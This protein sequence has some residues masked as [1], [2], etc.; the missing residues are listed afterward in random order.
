VARRVDVV[1]V[2]AGRSRGT[3]F[4]IDGDRVLTALHVIG[5]S[6]QGE[7]V[8]HDSTIQLTAAAAGA[9]AFRFLAAICTRQDVTEFDDQLDWACIRVDE[10]ALRGVRPLSLRTLDES[11]QSASWDTYGFPDGAEED[12]KATTGT[13]ASTAASF[14]VRSV[15]VAAIQVFSREAAAAGGG[16]VRGY[17]GAPVIVDGHGVGILCA[18]EQENGRS[19]EGTLYAIPL[20]SIAGRLGLP[21]LPLLRR[22]SGEAPE[23]HSRDGVPGPSS[24]DWER[25]VEAI[26]RLFCEAN[27]RFATD[28]LGAA[29]D[30]A[31]VVERIVD[32]L[33][34]RELERAGH[35]ES[36]DEKLRRLHAKGVIPRR[37]EVHFGTVYRHVKSFIHPDTVPRRP[38]PRELESGFGSLAIV[39]EWFFSYLKRPAPPA[40]RRPKRLNEALI[41]ATPISTMSTATI[42]TRFP[43][44]GE[45]SPVWRT[46]PTVSSLRF[47]APDGQ[48]SEQRS[49]KVEDAGRAYFIGR[50]VRKDGTP[51]DFAFPTTK[52]WAS[53]SHDAGV[54]TTRDREVVLKNTSGKNNMFVRG[55]VL[56]HGASRALR[57]G[58]SVQLGRCVGT[59]AD[60]RY[61]QATQASAIDPYTGLLSRLGLRSEIANVLATGKPRILLVLRGSERAAYD[62]E[63]PP[64]FDPERRAADA[65]LAI[66][67]HDP[68]VPIA[69]IGSDVAALLAT[70]ARVEAYTAVASS[71]LG[72]A[73][74]AGFLA[75][76]GMADQ[77]GPRLEACLGALSRIAMSGSKPSGPADLAKYALVPAPLS[78]FAE[79]AQPLFQAGGGAV[80]FAL[81]EIER[82]EDVSPHALPVLELELLEML[83]SRM[84]PRDL[85]SF[86]GPGLLAFATPGDVERFAHE[87][88]VTW[89][90]RGPATV[91]ALEIDRS[92]SA[93]ALD[94]DDLRELPRRAPAL[95]QGAIGILGLS[96]FPSPFAFAAR[97]IDEASDEVGREQRLIELVELAWQL[98]AFVLSAGA[99]AAK[100]PAGTAIPPPAGSTW[101]APWRVIARE[102]ALRLKDSVGRMNDLATAALA[103]DS[104]GPFQSAMATIASGAMPLG[105]A[106]TDGPASPGGVPRLERAVRDV[107]SALSPLRGW[108]LAAV[109]DA[110]AVDVDGTIQRVE[111]VDYTGA[112][113]Q[114]SRRHVSVIGFRSL[115]RFVY[116]A[117][118]AEGLAVA[119][120]PFVRRGRSEPA[121]D[122]ELFLAVAPIVAPGSHSYRSVATGRQMELPVTSKQLGSGR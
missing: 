55:E 36:F 107:V 7:L 60:G 38:E 37:E 66:H 118:W 53:I 29:I 110:E 67:R 18:A 52:T 48:P 100:S 117:R 90:A 10:E 89:H 39:V 120:E 51:N 61:Y 108:T 3:G 80:L 82:L 98:L 33:I 114:G 49:F 104:D 14:R 94:L 9:T 112:S 30:A 121:A 54:L 31:H 78:T 72:A 62:Q 111:Y 5:S 8:L 40:S 92:I 11:A 47:D 57:H 69:A 96:G 34:E 13:I 76:R 105:G 24:F 45:F 25:K 43:G 1:R 68:S 109:E 46:T 71:T 115:G 4:L 17:S 91:N 28:S 101:P 56:A 19:V 64:G 99:R 73:S 81:G 102:A 23:D 22:R 97:S 6:G 85:V 12:G 106:R 41:D 32:Y 83:G 35:D 103:A 122:E 27:D 84:G 116:L 86:A 65:A 42:G 59:F 63:S 87:T 44:I 77:A 21:P 113:A 70:D 88:S 74:V 58:D 20:A 26:A 93:H 75:L 15:S 119:L 95:A 16:V 50:D 79:K 2:V